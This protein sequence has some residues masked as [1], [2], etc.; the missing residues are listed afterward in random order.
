[1][2]PDGKPNGEGRVVLTRRATRGASLALALL[3]PLGA[4]A[5]IA[6]AGAP[7]HARAA[8]HLVARVQPSG[9]AREVLARATSGS[10]ML[11][12]PVVCAVTLLLLAVGGGGLARRRAGLCHA[13]PSRAP[14]ALRSI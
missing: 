5:V 13:R 10:A 6:S 1:M 9:A 12:E 8:D 3:L 14:P 7:R 4:A 2:L 11:R